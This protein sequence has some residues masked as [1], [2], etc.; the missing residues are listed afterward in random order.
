VD[1]AVTVTEFAPVFA[2]VKVTGVPEV[3]AVAS[4]KVPDAAGLMARFTVFVNVPVPVTV[5]VQIAD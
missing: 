4:L 3:T 5:E 2:G 1:V